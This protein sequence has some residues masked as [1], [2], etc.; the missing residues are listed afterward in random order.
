MDEDKTHLLEIVGDKS[1]Q[2]TLGS[3]MGFTVEKTYNCLRMIELH[4]SSKPSLGKE[5]QLRDNE[6]VQLFAMVSQ[7]L[8][9][10]SKTMMVRLN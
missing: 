7:L 8:V 10:C 9:R 1:L 2:R 3:V 6:L 5:P 4:A